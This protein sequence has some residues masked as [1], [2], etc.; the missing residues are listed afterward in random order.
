MVT[1]EREKVGKG[2]Q[3]GPMG[4]CSWADAEEKGRAGAPASPLWV[5]GRLGA[6]DE[7]LHA[8][9]PNFDLGN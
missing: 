6:L 2:G 7:K 8:P 3:I 1:E 9:A 5:G 4:H